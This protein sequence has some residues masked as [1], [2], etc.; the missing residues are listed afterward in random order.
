MLPQVGGQV[1]ASAPWH[2]WSKLGTRGHVCQTGGMLV[3]EKKAGSVT[4]GFEV[5]VLAHYYS[6]FGM[7]KGRYGDSYLGAH[8][9]SK[10]GCANCP[11]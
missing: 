5:W 10:L 2:G 7:V 6:W 4:V 9:E 11:H 3:F 8:R 1:L